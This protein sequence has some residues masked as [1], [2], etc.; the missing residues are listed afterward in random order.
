MEK[1]RKKKV[2]KRKP[3]APQRIAIKTQMHEHIVASFAR[4]ALRELWA[5]SLTAYTEEARKLTHERRYA[6][7]LILKEI[8][9]DDVA[10]LTGFGNEQE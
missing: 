4:W 6:L 3:L 5:N 7:D 1:P 9:M 10:K 8:G 2:K